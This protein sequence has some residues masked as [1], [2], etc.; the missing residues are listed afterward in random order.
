MMDDINFVEQYFGICSCMLDAEGI[1]E[2]KKT[3]SRMGWW[4]AASL[5]DVFDLLFVQTV[6]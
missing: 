6:N 5:E 3:L 2:T 4:A 1:A